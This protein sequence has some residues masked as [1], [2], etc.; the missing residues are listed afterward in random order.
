MGE[1]FSSVVFD[2]NYDW[3]SVPKEAG[4]IVYKMTAAGSLVSSFVVNKPGLASGITKQGDFFWLSVTGIEDFCGAYKCRGNGSVVASF[5]TGAPLD[6]TYENNH[7]W[8]AFSSTVRCY[9][10]SN[11]PAVLPA[12]VGRIKVLFK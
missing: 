12:S 9:D 6:C 10:V 8:I 2:A 3:I 5:G 7:L 1:G 11:A 4:T